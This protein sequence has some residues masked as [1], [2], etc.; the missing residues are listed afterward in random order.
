MLV[1]E[2]VGNETCLR[3]YSEGGPV[4]LVLKATLFALVFEIVTFDLIFVLVLLIWTCW[5]FRRCGSR[6]T[7]RRWFK[8]A[9]WRASCS[10]GTLCGGPTL[11][12]RL[13]WLRSGM[14]SLSA[15]LRVCI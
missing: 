2:N 3:F 15:L 1:L 12:C 6:E 8:T 14:E 13:H 10:C 4:W 11:R 9:L 7:E 5:A